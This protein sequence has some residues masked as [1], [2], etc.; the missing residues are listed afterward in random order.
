[1]RIN[2]LVWRFLVRAMIESP[3]DLNIIKKYEANRDKRISKLDD[4]RLR[5]L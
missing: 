5:G 3:A 1:M 4:K 2:R